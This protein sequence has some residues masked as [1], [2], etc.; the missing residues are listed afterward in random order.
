MVIRIHGRDTGDA[1]AVI[2]PH[3]VPGGGPLSSDLRSLVLISDGG[4]GERTKNRSIS[5]C[6]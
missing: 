3:D 5:T 4:R 6:W 1:V 2:E